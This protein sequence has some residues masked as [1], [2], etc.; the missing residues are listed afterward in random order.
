MGKIVRIRADGTKLT[1]ENI[2]LSSNSQPALKKV[3]TKEDY[4]KNFGA[5]IKPF[6]KGHAP[7]P[8]GGRRVGSTS[9]K[10][11]LKKLLANYRPP[12]DVYNEL[13]KKY[14]QIAKYEDC[15]IDDAIWARVLDQAQ[16][17]NENARDF[18]ADRTEGKVKDTLRLEEENNVTTVFNFDGVSLDKLED[19]LRTIKGCAKQSDGSEPV[20]D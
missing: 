14:P 2:P 13:K 6:E 19:A 1:E 17:G 10:S 8:G 18:V 7:L 5:K 15:T 11:K 3:R 16:R 4:L 20:S 9:I 12:K